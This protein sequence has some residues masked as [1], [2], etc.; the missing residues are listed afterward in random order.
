MSKVIE[1]IQNRNKLSLVVQIDAGQKA[2]KLAFV[3]HGYTGH[4]LEPH[5]VAV[6]E[7]FL[8]NGYRVV[9]FDTT[10]A[11]GESGGRVQDATYTN[12]ITDLGDVIQ[13][14]SSQEWFQE[15]FILAGHSMG[16][17]SVAWYTANHAEQVSAVL[18]LAPPVNYELYTSTMPE[19]GAQWRVAGVKKKR[20]SS[21]KSCLVSW[22]TIESIKPYD[23]LGVAHAITVP[24]LNVVGDMDQSCPLAH[25]KQFMNLVS[26]SDASLRVIKGAQH[27]YRNAKSNLV[28]DEIQTLHSVVSV[29]LSSINTEN[30]TSD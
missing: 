22:Q 29:W 30:S 2:D 3:Q 6:V 14:A 25:Q 21:G 15:P 11:A 17:Q 9:S 1:T 20:L 8:E 5:I 12:Y 13:W 7:A 27:S 28:G 10:N 24:T 23:L 4:R 26:S 18:A 19:G 16:A